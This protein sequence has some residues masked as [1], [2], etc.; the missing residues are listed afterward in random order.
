MHEDHD[1]SRQARQKD[2]LSAEDLGIL[3]QWHWKYGTATFTN[4]RQRVQL[5]LFMLF[6]AFTGSRPDALF[7]EDDSSSKNSQESSIND[8]S[9]NILADNSDGDILVD[10]GSESNVQN[11]KRSGTVCY[12]DI[13]L[14]FLRNSDNPERDIL[15][16]E[17]NFRNFKGRAKDADG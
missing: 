16:A 12:G 2:T 9:D 3:L 10:D 8:L 7:G 17:V 15:M 1:V 11:I 5:S 14:F 13:E 6:S 4:E